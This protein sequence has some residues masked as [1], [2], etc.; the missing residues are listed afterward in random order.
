MRVSLKHHASGFRYTVIQ[1][2]ASGKYLARRLYK[3]RA[4]VEMSEEMKRN[5]WVQIGK[6]NAKC[7]ETCK[8]KHVTKHGVKAIVKSYYLVS[9]KSPIL[10]IEHW[11]YDTIYSD[12]FFV[13]VNSE[14]YR[15]SNTTIRHVSKYLREMHLF[16]GLDLSY[17]E[18]KKSMHSKRMH[19][20]L[21]DYPKE[22]I[23]VYS[24]TESEIKEFFDDVPKY[25]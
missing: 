22:N 10:F 14:K 23:T 6:S 12:E 24:R 17:L 3:H 19:F 4:L 2:L 9:Y 18:L 15:F 7:L 25:C 5:V 11:K 20:T 21:R 1:R 8:R 13:H 16:A